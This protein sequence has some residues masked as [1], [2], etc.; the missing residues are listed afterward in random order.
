MDFKPVVDAVESLV[1]PIKK[2]IEA[3]IQSIP[4]EEGAKAYVE[5]LVEAELIKIAPISEIEAYINKFLPAFI[6]P[7]TPVVGMIEGAVIP[8][9]EIDAVKLATEFVFGLIAKRFGSTW[10]ADLKAKIA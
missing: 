9:V 8:K 5:G 2:E 4:D 10:F 1:E 3:A 7:F 6:K